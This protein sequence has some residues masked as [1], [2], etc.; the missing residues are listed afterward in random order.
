MPKRSCVL[1]PSLLSA[2][3]VVA[4]TSGGGC[5]TETIPA[6]PRPARERVSG[7][8][9]TLGAGEAH[10]TLRLAPFGLRVNDALGAVALDTIDKDPQISGDSAHAYGGL[11]ATHHET[12]FG[13]AIIEGWDHVTGED[14]PWL[15]ATSV[16]ALTTATDAMGQTASI[17]LFDP[18]R[19]ATTLHLDVRV[20]GAEVRLDAKVMGAVPGP[21]EP[22][23]QMGWSFALPDDEHFFGLGERFVT[24]DHRGRRYECW[25][26]EGGIGG[27]EKRALG[28]DNPSPNGPGMTH[29]P[30]PFY[31]SSKGYG[32]WQET[33]YRTGFV[34]GEDGAKAQ[35]L[36]AEEPALHLRVLVHRDPKQTL[37]HFTKLTGRAKLPAP[38]VFGPRRRV[39]HGV[40]LPKGEGTPEEE[41]LRRHH[42]PTTMVDDTTHFL[43]TN[44]S[45]DQQAFLAD[46]NARMHA[47]GY[48]TI[49]YFNSYVSLTDARAKPL[50][51]YGRMHDLFVRDD[52]G[53]EFDTFMVSAGGQTVATIDL[54][55]PDAVEW[56]ESLQ[57]QAIALGYDGWMLD[58]GEYL[59]QK[60]RMYDG[61]SGWEMHNAF[62]IVY[63]HAAF[64]F[65]R[66][67][68]GDD[69]MFYARAGYTGTQ[70][71]VP[72]V[73]SGDPS[74]SF[75]DGKGL[76]ANVRAGINAGL[77]GIPFWG[78]DISGY[79]CLN[80]PPPD[81]E[82]Y[83]RW[84]EFGALSSDMHDENACAQKPKD[85]PE[86]WTI[87]SDA[88]TTDVYARYASL[89]TR[90][91]P[92]LYAAGKEAEELGLPVI[93]HPLLMNPTSP[94]AL[95]SELEYWFGPSLYV[96]PVVR[97][98]ERARTFW[99]PPGTWFDWWTMAPTT[100][101]A[102]VTRDAPLDLLPMYLRSGGIVAMLD[103]SVETLAPDLRDD[104]VSMDD[105]AGIL[106][107]RAGIDLGADAT[108]TAGAGS[109]RLVDGTT[110]YLLLSPGAVALP[111][112]FTLAPD[113][114]TLA[115]C[116]DCGRI[117]D[118]PGGAKRVR[119]TTKKTIDSALTAGALL[120]RASRP[121]RPT[122]F[123]WDVA[124]VPG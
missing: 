30:I 59:P 18:A 53:K 76:P 77:S 112:S 67:V 21:D 4:A 96:A 55:K 91:N 8:D 99:L 12:T 90:L 120:L 84:A 122:K 74:A 97:R 103:P 20:E 114:A 36:Y 69:F 38:W 60:A 51:D 93:R 24:V 100:G 41:S 1:A 88:E 94:D 15:H 98:G 10:V 7:P 61:R 78:S 111:A 9:V 11:G 35:R 83:L 119:I 82:L 95:S 102:K 105:M 3:V 13:T 14:A 27:G 34:F 121:P 57:G 26:E 118:L 70:A 29:V 25:V 117:D 17:D 19:E 47:L 101:N 106:D 115:K 50:V 73:W 104:V 81:K 33:T 124:V 108:G 58:F 65:L 64:D 75:D 28:P 107:V 123:R 85:A 44:S 68:R 110:F 39:D 56:F 22:F 92:Y 62:P 87:W 113:E 80:D 52:Q 72:V 49:G 40:D 32:L 23:N 2:L 86:K 45:R 46:W 89:H 71:I 66:R 42:V 37:A 16:A 5:S 43:P 63:Q 79:T 48:K 116:D 109:T 6:P 31:L 54:T